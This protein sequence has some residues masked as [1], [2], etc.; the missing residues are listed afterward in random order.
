MKYNP[1]L[2]RKGYGSTVDIDNLL[3]EGDKEELPLSNKRF[4]NRMMRKMNKK[5][6]D[7]PEAFFN[8]RIL[9][10]MS[11]VRLVGEKDKK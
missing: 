8:S 1:S 5:I 9:V 7:S 3:F 4:L 11:G 6:T 2:Y 10:S